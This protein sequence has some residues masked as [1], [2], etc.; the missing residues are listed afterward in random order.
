MIFVKEFI[1]AL[2][3]TVGFSVMFNVP[4]KLLFHVG[5]TGAIGWV[6]YSYI[7]SFANPIIASFIASI[8]ISILGEI[9][10]RIKKTPVTVF[11]I[12][13]IVPIVPGFAMYLSV[14]NMINNNYS[15]AIDITIQTAFTAVSI[16]VGI[17]LVTSISKILKHSKSKY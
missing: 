3:A 5:F 12:P 8:A 11:V 7:N 2:F 15:K 9:L 17:I 4:K 14:A 13:G 16:S 10:A 1:F 6:V